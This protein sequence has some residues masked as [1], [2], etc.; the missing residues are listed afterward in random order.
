M[1]FNSFRIKNNK[2]NHHHL[3][4]QSRAHPLGLFLICHRVHEIVN[5]C[6]SVAPLPT[7]PLKPYKTCF[8]E[9]CDDSGINTL[10]N[11]FPLNLDGFKRV[12]R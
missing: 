4:N 5:A 1:N 2:N 11:L 6:Q 10:S 7:I 9:D 8:N 3:P 12:L